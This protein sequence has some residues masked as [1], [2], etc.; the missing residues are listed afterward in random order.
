MLS[1]IFPIKFLDQS[2]V[3]FIWALQNVL[4]ASVTESP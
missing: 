4:F 1:D 2:Y 3:Y